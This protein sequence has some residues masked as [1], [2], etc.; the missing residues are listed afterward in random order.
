[1]N[2]RKNLSRRKRQ[3][4]SALLVSLMVMVGL[5]LLGLGFVLVSETENAIALNDRNYTQAQAAA[6]TGV[7]TVVEWLQDAPWSNDVGLLPKNV[8]DFKTMRLT[9]TGA[10][11]GYYKPVSSQRLCDVPFKPAGADRFLGAD[12]NHADIW[13][14]DTYPDGTA[15]AKGK[16]FLDDLSAKLFYAPGGGIEKTRISDIRVFAPPIPGVDPADYAN[17]YYDTDR[18]R[19]GVA[20]IRVTAQKLVNG[21]VR[22]ERA[23]RAV[24]QET[25]FPTVD[26]AI[27]TAGSLVGQGSF[28]VYW[29]KVLSEQSMQ[30]ARQAVGMPWFD[31]QNSIWFEY[32]YDTT[33]Q[34]EDVHT[35]ATGDMVHAPDGMIDTDPELAKF[36][37]VAQNNGITATNALAPTLAQWQGTKALGN[38]LTDGAVQWKAVEGRPYRIDAT[39]PNTPNGTNSPKFYAAN[40]WFYQMLGQTLKDPWLHARARGTAKYGN[41]QGTVPCS[42]ATAPH[43]CDYDATSWPVDMAGQRYSNIFQNQ[44]ANNPAVDAAPADKP[45]RLIANFPAMDYD[46]WKAV[47]QAN[48]NQPGSGIYFF[49]Y[50]GTANDFTGP[51]GTTQDILLWLNAAPD[52]NG[53]P[54]NGLGAGFYF[55]DSK[56]GK[57][58]QFNKGGTLTP[59]VS[60]NAQV[61]SPY[62]LRG[63]IYLNAL[64]YG[65]SGQGS[66]TADDVYQMPGEP[67]RD[68]GYRE[69]ETTG[70]NKGN[71]RILPVGST[72]PAGNFSIVG[73]N[74]GVWDFQD[75]NGNGQF[76][77]W[78]TDVTKGG[79]ITVT[80]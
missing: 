16:A 39:L 30:L 79:T 5:S 74:N 19:Y 80:T 2:T 45:E 71:F 27:E 12:P 64:T 62:Q 54:K 7:K 77:V 29:G 21:T 8:A 41:G 17:G 23:V 28:R 32:G 34:R 44:N 63:Y 58:P 50:A 69:V 40:Q 55:F 59:A 76:D 14:A 10:Q 31:A 35:Y 36:A 52:A 70:P 46:F 47:A 25:P 26:G 60:I 9:K 53:K 15:N 42:Q 57:N 65:T 1:M 78:V 4:G 49:S 38:T 48:S 66:I 3:K 24:V 13:I 56:N 37:Y 51:G 18:P 72:L 67:F 6:E 11:Y 33:L 73:A 22:A 75:V 43:P 20:T 61:G 68:I